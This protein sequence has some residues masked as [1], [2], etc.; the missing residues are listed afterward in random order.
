[1][2]QNPKSPGIRKTDDQITLGARLLVALISAAFEHKQI[3]NHNI[4]A[5]NRQQKSDSKRR[6][7]K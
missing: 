7:T 5:S 4:Y 6:K 1:M 3:K 2:K